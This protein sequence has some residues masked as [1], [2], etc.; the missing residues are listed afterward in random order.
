[1]GF[2]NL[3]VFAVKFLPAVARDRGWRYAVRKP[4]VAG[5]K[6]EAQ[7]DLGEPQDFEMARHI[8][9]VVA[10]IIAIVILGSFYQGG[11]L[12]VLYNM[13]DDYRV[14]LVLAA[15]MVVVRGV[16]AVL[17]RW[18]QELLA[19]PL[20][21]PSRPLRLRDMKEMLPDEGS[22]SEM[23]GTLAVEHKAKN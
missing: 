13:G 10:A 21:S 4:V 22:M 3:V 1:M 19:R 18:I 14:G 12:A 5:E 7:E 8:L 15:V 6:E 17:F 20:A 11:P 16:L 2:V 23:R 9:W